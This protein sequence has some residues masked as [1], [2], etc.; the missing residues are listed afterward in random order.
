MT[1]M[2]F[3]HIAAPPRLLLLLLLSK[4]W[5]IIC[6]T[7]LSRRTRLSSSLASAAALFSSVFLPYH[8]HTYT[9]THTHQMSDNE[10]CH[11]GV[12]DRGHVFSRAINT[13]Y[14]FCESFRSAAALLSS[15]FLHTHTHTR[16]THATHNTQDTHI[17]LS[18]ITKGA[19][20]RTYTSI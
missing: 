3:I 13:F 8:T 11:G 19:H 2:P 18:I 20:E 5:N 15:I 10:V 1:R 14:L 6:S 16:N 9:H 12:T 17:G 4:N 7:S